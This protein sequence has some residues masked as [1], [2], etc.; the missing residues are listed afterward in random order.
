LRHAL[1][2]RSRLDRREEGFTLLD[3]EILDH[4]LIVMWY[5][6]ERNALRKFR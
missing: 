1:G 2:T 5:L 4:H 6:G 3:G